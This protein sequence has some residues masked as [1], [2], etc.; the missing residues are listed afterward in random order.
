MGTWEDEGIFFRHAKGA[1]V[2]FVLVCVHTHMLL[3]CTS[4]CTGH[5]FM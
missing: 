2:R 3:L 4:P 5:V 1:A